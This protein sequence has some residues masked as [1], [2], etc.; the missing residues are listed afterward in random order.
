MGL[1]PIDGTGQG[2]SPQL[3]G[4]SPDELKKIMAGL[5]RLGITPNDVQGAPLVKGGPPPKLGGLPELPPPQT[6]AVAVDIIT[7]GKLMS[8]MMNTQLKTGAEGV[9][10]KQANIQNEFEARMKKLSDY[11]SNLAKSQHSGFFGKLFSALGHL[12]KG[13]MKGFKADMAQA[14]KDNPVLGSLFCVVMAAA[15]IAG[16]PFMAMTAAVAFVPFMMADPDI[17]KKLGKLCADAFGGDE[18]KWTMAIA[19]TGAVLQAAEMIAISVAVGIATG[20][21]GVAPMVAMLAGV[22]AALPMAAIGAEEGYHSIK[23]AKYGSQATKDQA[24]AAQLQATIQDM[25]GDMKQQ[26]AYMKSIMDCLLNLLQKTSDGVQ[27]NSEAMK[28]AATS[29][30]APA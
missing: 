18:K 11:F 12:F 2:M 28:T 4:L 7:I 24:A 27:S 5:Q 17:S 13:D 16:G 8:D 26:Q 21:A 23:S 1:G 22:L 19:I 10:T 25:Q 14:F 20:G 15:F 29:A 30:P 9:K 6:T 3:P